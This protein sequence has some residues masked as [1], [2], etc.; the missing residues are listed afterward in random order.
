MTAGVIDFETY[1]PN[2]KLYGP[3]WVF[4]YHYPNYTF[5][6]LGC[7]IRLV[8]EGYERK[9]LDLGR[10]EDIE[11]LTQFL[12]SC[13]TLIMHNAS[14]DLGC[15]LYFF[16]NI[17]GKEFDLDKYTIDDT[18]VF[19]RIYDQHMKYKVK[20]SPYSLDSL[21]TYYNLVKKESNILHEWLWSSG[22][23]QAV[24]KER[25]GR[26]CHKMPSNDML[27]NFA[28]SDMRVFPINII[29]EYANK[30]T[31]AT[32][33]LWNYLKPRLEGTNFEELSD[34][35]KVCVKIK[36]TGMR[37]DLKQL[38]IVSDKFKKARDE[39]EVRLKDMLGSDT[40]NI[41]ST[42]Q[43][44]EILSEQG[45]VIPRT[46]L[47]N[48]SIKSEWLDTR[49]EEVFKMLSR[50]RK[51]N[52]AEKDYI[53]KVK[54]YQNAIPEEYR[55]KDYGWIYPS[56]HPY[57]ATATGRFTSGGG[58]GC[59][60]LSLHQIPRRDEEFGPLCRSIFVAHEG[61]TLC[62]GDF[63]SQESRLQVHY[64]AVIGC[65]GAQVIVDAWN[66]N[67]SMK[68]HQK[69]A[70]LTEIEY[71]KAKTINLGLSYDMHT[72][73]LAVR[74]GVTYEEAEEILKQYHRLLPF[75]KP[76][77]VITANSLKKNGYIKTIGGRKLNIDKPYWFNGRFKT[78]ERK[79][80]SKLIQG[81]AV[82]Q[83]VR[84]MIRAYKTGLKLL[85]S[86]HDE[87][88][89]STKSPDVDSS[90]LKE[91]MEGS[92]VLKVPVLADVGTGNSW[93]DGKL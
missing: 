12:D 77:Q 23:Y 73:S 49:G 43:L 29:S 53:Q 24:I 44:G 65:E 8:K 39:S 74:L 14:Y 66:E 11:E 58:T 59:L 35:V 69:V 4:K 32:E 25:T 55:N 31:E 26:N 19:A 84:S 20:K 60:E 17:L 78:Q 34:I 72:K 93:M 2:L 28:K 41:N 76:L 13:D 38:D 82:D 7:S 67:P 85:F 21:T 80:L 51:S 27:E 5:E 86:I 30:D 91:C 22:H 36:L 40:V 87:L 88:I 10:L 54:K 48:Y 75:M 79:G 16:K 61:E 90:K 52:K 1:D 68:Y 81:S 70:E 50:Y 37:I 64:A 57:A 6:V 3:G 92:Y 62:V 47:G 18:L 83:C 9:Y 56:L 42:E 33:S 45:Y 63:N 89:I 46:E 71:E 15:L